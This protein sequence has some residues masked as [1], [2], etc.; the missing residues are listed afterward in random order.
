MTRALAR[1]VITAGE[2]IREE[3]AMQTARSFRAACQCFALI[4]ALAVAPLAARAQDADDPA[5]NAHWEAHQHGHG[6][7]SGSRHSSHDDYWPD[8]PTCPI[9]K[10]TSRVG[11]DAWVARLRA[12]RQAP[13]KPVA[14]CRLGSRCKPPKP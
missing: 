13:A 3:T 4:G 10:G 2:T 12:C 6:P 14:P 1:R 7:P 8:R 11:T 5:P 9:G